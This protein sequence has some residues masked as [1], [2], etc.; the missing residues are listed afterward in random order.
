[1]SSET[2][3]FLDALLSK[4]VQAGWVP[5]G[6]AEATMREVRGVKSSRKKKVK[7]PELGT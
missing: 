1:V 3:K 4:A 2:V 5:Q 6:V 7:S